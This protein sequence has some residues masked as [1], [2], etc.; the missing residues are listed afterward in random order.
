MK[1]GPVH[2]FERLE[3][4]LALRA[5]V[6]VEEDGDEGRRLEEAVEHVA[7]H[8]LDLLVQLPVVVVDQPLEDGILVTE[9]ALM[10]R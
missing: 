8:R 7:V 5:V 6:V 2:L 9:V 10:K 1:S 4:G 3:D